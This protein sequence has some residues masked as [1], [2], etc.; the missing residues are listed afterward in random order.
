M[1]QMKVRAVIS[2]DVYKMRNPNARICLRSSLA[3]EPR[4][5]FLPFLPLVTESG[6]KIGV[7]ITFMN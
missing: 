3:V 2:V 4:A 1:V 6:F 5:F 7:W